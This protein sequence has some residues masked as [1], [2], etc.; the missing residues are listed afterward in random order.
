MCGLHFS[1]SAYSSDGRVR[2]RKTERKSSRLVKGAV[3]SEFECFPEHLRP[4]TTKRKAPAERLPLQPK[5]KRLDVAISSSMVKETGGADSACDRA[6][7]CPE[8][9]QCVKSL[10][11]K[12]AE[13]EDEL[14][15][16]RS[17]HAHTSGRLRD[18]EEKR[19]KPDF[20]IEKYA[21]DNQKNSLLHWVLHYRSVHGV[22]PFL[23]EVSS[24]NANLERQAHRI[25]CTNDG[26]GWC[27]A[28][29]DFGKSILP[30]DGPVTTRLGSAR[31]GGS[32]RD[33]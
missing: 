7:E 26:E 2:E 9:C 14:E 33:K 18:A 6:D 23:G 1:P 27:G 20:S 10:V 25:W 22:L 15:N 29:I 11:D 32:I 17:A 4:A 12:V 8:H 19:Q 5:A 16:E 3:P 31:F 21:G 30:C 24:A 13:L 28:Q